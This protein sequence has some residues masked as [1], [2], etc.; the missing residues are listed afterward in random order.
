[1]RKKFIDIIKNIDYPYTSAIVNNERI[2]FLDEVDEN[3]KYEL[4]KIDD[5]EGMRTYERTLTFLIS[6]IFN[7]FYNL[8]IEIKHSFGDAIYAE[9][10]GKNNIEEIIPKIKEEMNNLIKKDIT[11]KKLTLRK[12]EASDL[13]FKA[14]SN[15]EP[16]LIK[17]LSKDTLSLYSINNYYSYF[18]GPLLPKTGMIKVFD[19]TPFKS[20][21]LIILP[22]KK[23]FYKLG[24]INKS[25][26][27]F[28]TFEESKK[29]A[30]S[31]GIKYAG[32]LN[33][34]IVK[35]EIIELILSQEALHEKKIAEISEMIRKKNSKLILISGPTSSGK[36]TLSKKLKIY[37]KVLGLNSISI[38]TDDYFF[39]RDK[40]PKR[41]NGEPDY[42]SIDA[43]DLNLL[44]KHLD[45]LIDNQSIDLPKFNFATGKQEI[46]EKIIPQKNSIII[47]E[48]LHSINPVL[49]EKIKDSLK[50]KIYISPLT[51][52]NF[53]NL[54]RI[55]TRD[56]RLIRRIVRDNV[57]RKITPKETIKKWSDVIGG[58][59]K[60]IFPFQDD[61]DTMFNSSLFYELPVLK[62]FAEKDLMS[63]EN[64]DKEYY[65]ASILIN[66][67]QHFASLSD[68]YVPTT[69]I[70]R[71]FIG[72]GL[73]NAQ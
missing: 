59:E 40:T 64:I 61:V 39:D 15:Y 48:G 26:K 45:L 19:I 18:L 56:V 57:F 4:I 65:K 36:T 42:E 51:Q 72:G 50:F 16:K 10:Q 25:K 71:E 69:S 29:W 31:L 27:L 22:D 55:P 20:G 9:V 6:Y 30:C 70:L 1:M 3:S 60:N 38:S 12:E 37:L 67:L 49:T 34:K 58:E 28:S 73:I 52:I 54:N 43:I 24:K 68:D 62:F 11:I 35:N 47:I 13:L 46:G 41:E 5:M 8:K 32:D 53:D 7:E 14:N 44:Q 33:E 17:Y 2:G 66:F 23:N 63:I 21:F